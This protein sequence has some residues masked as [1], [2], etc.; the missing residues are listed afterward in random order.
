MIW[1]CV[2]AFLILIL[3]RFVLY[4][5]KLQRIKKYF[6][7]Y[8][9]YLEEPKYE[10]NEFKPQI[11]QLFKDA[12]LPDFGIQKLEPVGFGK[13]RQINAKGYD[14]ITV[15]DEEV[16]GNVTS[17]F[18]EAIG[19]FR[20][21]MFQSVNPLFWVEF[22]F[23]LPQYLLEFVGVLPEKV[24]VKVVLILY[25]LAALFLGLKKLDIFAP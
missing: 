12:D 1:T 13:L 21:R 22:V 5:E 10:F 14:N 17:R 18:H 23:K 8:Q 4:F 25:W 11:V 6:K 19:V 7:L 20:Y 9:K 15:T 3:T 16:I 24:I 2:I